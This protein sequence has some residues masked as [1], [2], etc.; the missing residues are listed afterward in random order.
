[1]VAI[2]LH[3]RRLSVISDRIPL[4]RKGSVWKS[5]HLASSWFL[6]PMFYLLAPLPFGW[7]A[8]SGKSCSRDVKEN[9][10]VPAG[11]QLSTGLSGKTGAFLR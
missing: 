11:W 2:P 5:P 4:S 10:A 7:T 3:T 6:V 8:S 1:M 9:P